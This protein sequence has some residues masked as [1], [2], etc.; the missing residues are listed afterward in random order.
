MD[1][2]RFSRRLNRR[3]G[4]GAEM[5]C[6]RAWRCRAWWFIVPVDLAF[7]ALYGERGHCRRC[8]RDE[9]PVS[10]GMPDRA[11]RAGM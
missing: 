4:G 6:A 2:P 10:D 9:H 3:L 5:L 7:R 8:Y 1:L 11:R